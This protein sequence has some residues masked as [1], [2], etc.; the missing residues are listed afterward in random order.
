MREPG[1][2]NPMRRGNQYNCVFLHYILMGSRW[3]E[4]VGKF[5][6][7]Y[8]MVRRVLRTLQDLVLRRTNPKNACFPD[9]FAKPIPFRRR[10]RTLVNPFGTFQDVE[11][12][13]WDESDTSRFE[14][15]SAVTYVRRGKYTQSR[16][17]GAGGN[18]NPSIFKE[19]IRTNA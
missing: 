6:G 7:Q 8:E 11:N 5:G 12:H 17:S 14:H 18:L 9:D 4:S 10:F 2:C 3:R 13:F 19:R 1:N 15:P 16:R